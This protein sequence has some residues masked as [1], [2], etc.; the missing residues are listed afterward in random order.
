MDKVKYQNIVAEL[1]RNG[2][3]KKQASEEL[4]ITRQSFRLKL[5]GSSEWTIGE[6]VIL[7]KLLKKDFDYLFMN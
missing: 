1:A 2:I 5:V 6:I 3:S 4:G 7:M